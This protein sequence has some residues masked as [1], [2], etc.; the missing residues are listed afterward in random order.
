M[1]ES[2]GAFII[3]KSLKNHLMKNERSPKGL[4]SERLSFTDEACRGIKSL[5][6]DNKAGSTASIDLA[7]VLLK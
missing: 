1:K 6:E 2:S 3:L 4:L 7:F 5:A